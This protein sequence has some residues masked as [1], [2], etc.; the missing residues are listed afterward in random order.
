[1][2]LF[3]DYMIISNQRLGITDM[4]RFFAGLAVGLILGQIG[5][6]MAAVMIGD[7]GYLSGWNITVGGETVCSDPYIWHGTH[8]IECDEQ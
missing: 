6:A 1:M 7:D 2:Q 8:E 3:V 5:M 4:R